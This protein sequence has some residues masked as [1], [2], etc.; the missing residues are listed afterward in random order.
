M[1]ISKRALA[2]Q[3]RKKHV[4][5]HI[6][7]SASQPRLCVFR[8]AK[9]IYAQIIDDVSGKTLAASS[10]LTPAC[11]SEIQKDDDKKAVA[12]KVGLH[13]GSI[14]KDAGLS[15][16]TFERNGYRD[17]GRDAAMADGARESGLGF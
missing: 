15:A 9:H 14:A 10:S 13:L 3:R 8:S 1:T 17:H 4:R 12:K 2:R 11:L 5:K 16:V 6:S 7:G